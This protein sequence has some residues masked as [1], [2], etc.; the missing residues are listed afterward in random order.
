MTTYGAGTDDSNES[1]DHD[2]VEIVVLE[3]RAADEMV[4]KIHEPT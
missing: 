3:A 1:S 2:E 4:G